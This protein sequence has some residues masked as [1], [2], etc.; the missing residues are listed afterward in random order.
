MPT[1]Q[2]VFRHT[3]PNVCRLSHR[4]IDMVYRRTGLFTACPCA[5]RACSASISSARVVYVHVW[6][7]VRGALRAMA[8]DRRS[9]LTKFTSARPQICAL[10]MSANVTFSMLS[11]VSN[12]W[13]G[14]AAGGGEVAWDG[15]CCASNFFPHHFVDVHTF[16]L[17]PVVLLVHAGL[18]NV[19]RQTGAFE[20]SRG[21]F[22]TERSNCSVP[23]STR[24]SRRLHAPAAQS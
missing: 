11:C 23:H 6:M 14:A 1:A 13:V 24:L 10:S 18:A 20:E 16:V 5:M 8:C 17:P 12:V 21:G 3:E 19:V 4:F 7:W 9:S 22:T 2:A 15:A